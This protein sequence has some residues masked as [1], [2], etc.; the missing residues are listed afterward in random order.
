M[1]N[2]IAATLISLGIATTVGAGVDAS[3]MKIR[4]D[5]IITKEL[6]LT[7]TPIKKA[8]IA[9]ACKR[10][11]MQ[12]VI[13]G[14]VADGSTN[15]RV[16]VPGRAGTVKSIKIACYTKPAGGTNAVSVQKVNG[17]TA[18]TLLNAASFDPNTIT[19]DK[20]A[21][22]LT[23]TSTSNDLAVGATDL[24]IVT[25]EAGTQTTDAVDMT[26]EVEYEQ[27]DD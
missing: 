11:P 6:T 15:R 5:V 16:L 20:V 1:K 9:E 27:N 25:Y 22:A 21:Q 23:L 8:N 2:L 17:A 18:V 24:L 26:V 4:Q 7:T 3:P 12:A 14:T 19:A 10:I 13:S